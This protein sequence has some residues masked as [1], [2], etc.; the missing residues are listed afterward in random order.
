MFYMRRV[1]G[2]PHILPFGVFDD[3]RMLSY[4]Y[5]SIT[6]IIL[7]I[8]SLAVYTSESFCSR[9]PYILSCLAACCLSLLVPFLFILGLYDRFLCAGLLVFL[10]DSYLMFLSSA[11]FTASAL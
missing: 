9:F 8:H 5:Y 7:G 4:Y 3:V 11:C 10:S 2:S 1:A 6:S